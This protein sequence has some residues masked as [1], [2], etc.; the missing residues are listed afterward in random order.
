MKRL[1]P[2]LLLPCL[3]VYVMLPRTA[4]SAPLPAP[5]SYGMPGAYIQELLTPR[6][7]AIECNGSGTISYAGNAQLSDEQE[8]LLFN[9][10]QLYFESL[11]TLEVHDPSSLFAPDAQGQAEVNAILWGV[12]IGIRAMQ[13]ADYRLTAYDFYLNVRSVEVNE[14]GDISVR[15]Y[16]TYT[17]NFAMCPDAQTVAYNVRH[18]FVLT[19]VDG[20][21]YLRSHRQ[22]DSLTNILFGRSF[23]GGADEDGYMERM[24]QRQQELLA[25]ATE[26]LVQRGDSPPITQPA[27]D[28]AYD[29]DAA[30]AYA[31]Q[32][33]GQR[34]PKWYEYDSIGGNCQNFVSQALLAGGV[35]MDYTKPGLWKWY[36]D[37]PNSS[38]NSSGRS[39]AWTEVNA[40]YNYAKENRGYGLVASVDVPYDGGEVGDVI[41]LGTSE[42]WRHTVLITEVIRDSD[43]Y[44]IDYLVASNTADYLNFPVSAYYYPVKQL[45]KIYGYN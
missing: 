41:H 14:D 34:N 29:R 32:W 12:P 31:R 1:L 22:S 19:Q 18:N 23:V 33:V 35:P 9:F 28:H 4:S 6:D 40:F 7:A 21:W 30:V 3:C 24:R 8:Q 42:T 27:V 5:V 39:P 36:G 15:A 44:V 43:G 11:A 45:I 25:Q 37:T 16:D 20:Q 10:M 13:D 38:Y 17:V 2:C 26:S